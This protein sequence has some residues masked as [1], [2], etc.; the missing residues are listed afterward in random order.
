MRIKP[1][2]ATLSS[3][4]RGQTFVVWGHVYTYLGP[5]SGGVA[6]CSGSSVDGR[7][8]TFDYNLAVELL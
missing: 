2:R 6:V 1:K 5:V 7:V 3:L 8:E 4:R